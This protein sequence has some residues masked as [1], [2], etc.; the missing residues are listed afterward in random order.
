MTASPDPFPLPQPLG[1]QQIVSFRLTKNSKDAMKKNNHRLRI[2][3][4]YDPFHYYGSYSLSII[5]SHHNVFLFLFFFSVFVCLIEG[6]YGGSAINQCVF[7]QVCLRISIRD[8]ITNQVFF[9]LF[10]WFGSTLD[11][12][13]SHIINY[14]YYY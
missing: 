2:T 4:Q 6:S 9:Y 11:F 14:F 8:L 7:L 13:F 1:F 3:L 10:I 12:E 5:T